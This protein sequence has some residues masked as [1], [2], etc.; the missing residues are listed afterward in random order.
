M[1][2]TV[3]FGAE[4]ETLQILVRAPFASEHV[5]ESRWHYRMAPLSYIPCSRND[6]VNFFYPKP[7]SRCVFAGQR[8]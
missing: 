5:D 1:L 4:N 6:F 8:L 3:V 2:G 7:L